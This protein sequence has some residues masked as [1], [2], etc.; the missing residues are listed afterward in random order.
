MICI[1]TVDTACESVELVADVIDGC[2]PF[3]A[4]T[5]GWNHGISYLLLQ[6]GYGGF[7][8]WEL[9]IVKFH[10]IADG[11]SFLSTFFQFSIGSFLYLKS[12]IVTHSLIEWCITSIIYN[13]NILVYLYFI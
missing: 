10:L 1:S 7:L 11:D 2:D 13:I 9:Y 12:Y 8:S 4:A 3:M 5:Y 6:F